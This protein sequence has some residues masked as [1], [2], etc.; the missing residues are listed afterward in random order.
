MLDQTDHVLIGPDKSHV[1]DTRGEPACGEPALTS[2]PRIDIAYPIGE[3]G[4]AYRD[5]QIIVDLGDSAVEE[6]LGKV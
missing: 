3:P 1:N 4:C 6:S 5:A 2:T